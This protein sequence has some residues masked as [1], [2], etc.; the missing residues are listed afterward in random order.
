MYINGRTKKM[1]SVKVCVWQ[2]CLFHQYYRYRKKY[3]VLKRKKKTKVNPCAKRKNWEKANLFYGIS[4]NSHKSK[5]NK[6]RFHL[7]DAFCNELLVHK[8]RFVWIECILEWCRWLELIRKTSYLGQLFIHICYGQNWNL[9][10]FQFWPQ[11]IHQYS[12]N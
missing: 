7:L 3:K 9:T 2:L 5:I 8:I 4:F 12:V 6:I 10:K 11:H 1:A